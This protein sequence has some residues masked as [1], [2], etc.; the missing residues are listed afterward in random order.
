MIR[1]HATQQAVMTA[2]VSVAGLLLCGCATT[3]E[4]ELIQKYSETQ[5]NLYNHTGKIEDR[6]AFS[7]NSLFSDYLLYSFANSPRL[8]AAFDRWKAELERIP[9]ARSLN[10][11]ELSFDY[12]L[13][14]YEKKHQFG[15]MQKIP[16]FG[17]LGLQ[18][19]AASAKAEA[20]MHTFENARF[21]LY[22]QPQIWC[23]TIIIW[24]RKPPLPNRT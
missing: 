13:N 22:D 6:T 16:L 23:T 1:Q 20:A 10:D 15:L 9:Q 5:R 11:P 2:A 14:Q 21:M 24:D 8:R 17:E 12:M 7:T 4:T 19:R 18:S 3:A